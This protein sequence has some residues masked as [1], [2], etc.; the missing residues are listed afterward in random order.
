MS[1][2]PII[3]PGL[4]IIVSFPAFFMSQ[5][6]LLHINFS[7][8]NRVLLVFPSIILIIANPEIS[9]INGALTFTSFCSSGFNI[10]SF[11]G[12]IGND[13][14]KNSNLQSHEFITPS[15]SNTF[16]YPKLNLH[17]C[18]FQTPMY[19]FQTCDHVLLQ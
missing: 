11:S 1:T 5:T 4:R 2:I 7:F 12:C 16:L 8:I 17:S 19:Q 9:S 10:I 13:L 15:N 3:S 6:A 14:F 18:V